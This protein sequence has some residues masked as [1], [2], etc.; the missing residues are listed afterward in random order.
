MGII[1]DNKAAAHLAGDLEPTLDAL[2]TFQGGKR[3][4]A[5]FPRGHDQGGRQ[6]RVGG[7][8]VAQ[9]RQ[10]ER[11]HRIAMAHGE[12]LAESD[13]ALLLEFERTP[14]RPTDG[15]DPATGGAR[16]RKRGP[17]MGS[18]GVDDGGAILG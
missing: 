13:R 17:G 1:D 9:Q 7:L 10:A 6:Q 18:I 2:E 8:I 5:G 16:G 11:P 3:I 14:R 4:D 15:D 12:L